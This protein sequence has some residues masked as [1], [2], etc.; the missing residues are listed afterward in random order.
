MEHFNGLELPASAD[1][2]VHLRDG[3]MME[4]VTP[5]IRQGGVDMVYVMPNLV[6]P[7]TTVERALSYQKRLQTL[8]SDVTFLMSLYLHPS[9][10]PST[11]SE[12]KAAGIRGIKS[13]PA[14]VTTNSASGVV[15]YAQ[16]YP[17]FAAMEE[18]HLILNL[19]GESPPA[20][21]ITVLNAEE[22]FLPTLL[23]LHKRFPKLCIVL[24]HCTTAAAIAAVKACGPNVAG[25]ITAHHLFLIIDDWANDPF[26]YCKPVAKLPADRLALIRTAASGNP[27]FFLGTDSAPHAL[28]AK[29]G[30]GDGM[31]KCAAG[32][33]TQPY[34]TQ[35]VLEAFEDAV[36]KG[37]LQSE[38]L[39]KHALTGFLG[40]FGRKFYGEPASKERIR[41]RAGEDRVMEALNF[42]KDEQ[43]IVPFRRKEPVY[44]LEWM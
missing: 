6:P 42:G 5:T 31:G 43:R 41:V 22:A 3:D 29:R 24:E 4:A 44:S 15:D 13:Y 11:I 18:H 25:T 17:V 20:A 26:N 2:H 10:T 30:G 32:V 21:D 40:E 19:H 37:I 38:A 12:A 28:S 33:F 1:F 23:D 16:F 14:G 8:A 36:E 34:A 9:V 39:S 27:K 7:I 35:L